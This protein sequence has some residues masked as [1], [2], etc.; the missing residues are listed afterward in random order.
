[1]EA[2]PDKG[3]C[4]SG[5]QEASGTATHPGLKRLLLEGV[6]RRG[7]RRPDGDSLAG[8]YVDI[9]SLWSVWGRGRLSPS[10]TPTT[11]TH[12]VV[13]EALEQLA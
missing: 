2:E 4:V 8:H 7:R 10:I 11:S 6:E 3:S 1:M 12:A 9:F 13:L 5:L